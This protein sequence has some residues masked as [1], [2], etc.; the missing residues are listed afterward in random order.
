M[1]LD[2]YPHQPKLLHCT[3]SEKIHLYHPTLYVFC[4]GLWTV[5]TQKLEE[6]TCKKCLREKKNKWLKSGH[7]QRR[8]KGGVDSLGLSRSIKPPKNASK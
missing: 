2:K 4:R 1:E 5:R 8:N 6:V 7:A 3:T